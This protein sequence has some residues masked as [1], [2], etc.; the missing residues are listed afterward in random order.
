VTDD[1]RSRFSIRLAELARDLDAIVRI[2]AATFTN[3]VTR[4]SYEWE[5]QHSDVVRLWVACEGAGQSAQVLGYCAGWL[6]FDELHI[7]NL[8]VHP[9]WRRQGVAP[10]LLG[11]VLAD[12]LASDA[13]RATLEVRASNVPARRLYERFGFVVAGTRPAYYRDPVEDALIL[14]RGPARAAGPGP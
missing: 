3:P 12:A 10:C 2:D 11:H 14:W 5:A 1:S 7:N 4:E 6:I 8:A 9:E 13:T